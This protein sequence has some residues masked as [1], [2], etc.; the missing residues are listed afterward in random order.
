M[1]FLNWF[2]NLFIRKEQQ[3]STA[4]N[5]RPDCLK[6]IEDKP[7][8]PD[9]YVCRHK[10]KDAYK[11]FKK[12]N[13]TVK[14]VKGRVKGLKDDHIW[15]ELENKGELYWYDPTWYNYDPVKYGWRKASLYTDRRVIRNKI[16]G[17]IKPTDDH[18]PPPG[19]R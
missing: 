5:P 13:Y 16:H 15:M 8:V 2:K 6:T 10:C 12:H 17:K 19:R 7:C 11:C 3:N 18:S 9:I 4:S 1:G 14:V